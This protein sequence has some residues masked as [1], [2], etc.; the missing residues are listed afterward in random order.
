MV[1]ILTLQIQIRTGSFVSEVVSEVLK[2][3]KDQRHLLHGI[4]DLKTANGKGSEQFDPIWMVPINPNPNFVGREEVLEQLKNQL[5]GQSGQYQR[6]AVLH[7]LAGI[8]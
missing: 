6:I 7:G 5:L 4:H 3:Q 2:E 1:S 8:G